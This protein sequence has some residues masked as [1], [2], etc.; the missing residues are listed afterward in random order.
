MVRASS[1]SVS[2]S[3]SYSVATRISTGRTLQVAQPAERA[4]DPPT[5]LLDHVCNV[6]IAGWLTRDKAGFE[7]LVRTIEKNAL[8]DDHMIM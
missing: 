4:D 6:G 1:G 7:T 8:H 5:D 2:R 3:G